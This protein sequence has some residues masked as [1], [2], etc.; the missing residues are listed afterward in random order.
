VSHPIP[1]IPVVDVDQAFPLL[2]SDGSRSSSSSGSGNGTVTPVVENALRDVLGWRPRS[3]DTSAFE[4]ALAASFQLS[5]VEDHTVAAYSPR[6]YAIQ[7]DLGA[8]SGGQA[9][10]YSRAVSARTQM[11]TLLDGL[12]PLRPDADT[13]N[14][15]SYRRLVRD[16]VTTMI[17]ELGTPGGPRVAVVDAFLR[18]LL[19]A[20]PASVPATATADTVGG[21]LGQVRDQFG[22]TDAFVNNVDQESLRTAFWTL[23]DLVL[24]TNRAWVNLR[25]QF[26]GGPQQGF[27]GTEL[28][29]ISQ[30]L[31]AVAEQVDDVEAALDSVSVSVAERQTIT[32]AGSNG[33]TLDGLLT[34]VRTVVTEEGP[35]IARDT[36]RDGLRTSLMPTVLDLVDQV[37]RLLAATGRPTFNLPPAVINLLTIPPADPITPQIPLVSVA[38]RT[39]MPPGMQSSRVQIAVTGLDSLIWQLAQL[40]MRIA[41]FSGAVLFDVMALTSTA[42][43]ELLVVVRGLNIQPTLT[44]VFRSAGVRRR[45]AA[46]RKQVRPFPDRVSSDNETISAV[47]DLVE[48]N[49]WLDEF[50]RQG[51]PR[52]WVRAAGSGV[53]PR[54][55]HAREVPIRLRDNLTGKL[56]QKQT[57]P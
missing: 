29:L 8:V 27:L 31:G 15:E 46:L 45:N 23:V 37:E 12:T 3:Q 51:K 21:Q 28:V 44:P 7:A 53:Q 5:E 26:T 40:T 54:F 38:R 10:L 25:G 4:A 57:I 9:S 6:G 43:D 20:A 16:A 50:G 41:R 47:F 18:Q 30:L 36:G 13:E 35:R 42:N 32:L 48:L 24:D 22:L 39:P 11:I 1:S 34:W 52:P 2:T 55:V 14:C 49:P 19:G 56:V 33:L 17:T